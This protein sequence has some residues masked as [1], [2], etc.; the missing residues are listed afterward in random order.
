MLLKLLFK[1]FS[2]RIKSLCK[3][4]KDSLGE[5]IS[6]NS[7]LFLPWIADFQS[8]S[9]EKPWRTAKK[10]REEE[11]APEVGQRGVFHGIDAAASADKGD[12]H[13]VNKQMGKMIAKMALSQEK[14]KHENCLQIRWLYWLLVSK[15]YTWAKCLGAFDDQWRKKAKVDHNK[16]A[17][18]KCARCVGWIPLAVTFAC[19]VCTFG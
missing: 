3:T 8:R 16:S 13:R 11:K 4:V 5:M 15:M 12:M 14:V 19:R 9:R 1:I 6:P 2:S 7:F 10:E 17:H 18:C